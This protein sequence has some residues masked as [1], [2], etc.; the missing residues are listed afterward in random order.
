MSVLSVILMILQ[1]SSL[2]NLKSP[3]S[4]PTKSM[5]KSL[6]LRCSGSTPAP[7]TDFEKGTTV[8]RTNVIFLQV[9]RT[10]IE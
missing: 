3:S 10:V 6:K 5:L 1:L 9:V 8:S 7:L 2:E 4:L